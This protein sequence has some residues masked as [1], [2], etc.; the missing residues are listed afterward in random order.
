MRQF[1]IIYS[2]HFAM[3]GIDSEK[4]KNGTKSPLSECVSL[5]IMQFSWRL[6]DVSWAE[7]RNKF[8]IDNSSRLVCNIVFKLYGCMPSICNEMYRIS[9]LAETHLEFSKRLISFCRS[10][11]VLHVVEASGERERAVRLKA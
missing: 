4:R 9:L 10:H 11:G 1:S 7:S 5:S 2:I 6:R 3:R 8:R